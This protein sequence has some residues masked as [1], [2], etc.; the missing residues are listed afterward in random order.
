MS[1]LFV[2]HARELLGMGPDWHMSSWR[3]MDWKK[4][5]FQNPAGRIRIT[6]SC[7]PSLPDGRLCWEYEVKGTRKSV[8][9]RNDDHDAW[10]LAWEKRTGICSTCYSEAQ[11]H[12]GLEN[13]GWDHIKGIL[14]ETCRRCKGTAK[15]PVSIGKAAGPAQPQVDE[16]ASRVS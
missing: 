13:M 2:E 5:G 10:V 7:V 4:Y 16:G 9:I 11:P 8:M 12:P 14:L 6:G 1:N 3:S 15:A